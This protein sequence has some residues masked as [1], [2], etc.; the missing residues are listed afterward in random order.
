ME[1]EASGSTASPSVEVFTVYARDTPF[2]LTRSQIETD[3]PNY[4]TSAFLSHGFAESTTHEIRVDKHPRLF[5]LV[6]EHLSGYTFLPLQSSALPVWMSIEA[7]TENLLRD[8]KY[9]GLELWRDF[10]RVL[11]FERVCGPNGDLMLKTEYASV[12]GLDGKYLLRA[13]RVPLIPSGAG[14]EPDKDQFHSSSEVSPRGRRSGTRI[15]LDPY[16]QW[17]RAHRFWTAH[18]LRSWAEGKKEFPDEIPESCFHWEHPLPSTE[19]LLD[20]DWTD[21]TVPKLPCLRAFAEDCV[22]TAWVQQD[23]PNKTRLMRKYYFA[24]METIDRWGRRTWE[25]ALKDLDAQLIE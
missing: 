24:R 25:K 14:S 7:A 11:D 13:K 21:P 23:H 19:L 12:V 5:A 9:F 20:D 22:F 6:A 10:K 2:R 15:R 1:T 3:S 18:L 8:A 4:F 17:V 16:Y